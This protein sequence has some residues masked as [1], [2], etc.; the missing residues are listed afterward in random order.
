[1]IRPGSHCHNTLQ[2]CKSGGTCSQHSCTSSGFYDDGWMDNI[3]NCDSY[4][5]INVKLAA[6]CGEGSL[7]ISTILLLVKLSP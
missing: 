3:Q 5:F 1:M 7:I 2:C 4:I 6:K